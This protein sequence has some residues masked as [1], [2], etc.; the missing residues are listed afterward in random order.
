MD[1]TS[2][3]LRAGAQV[4][5]GSA[6]VNHSHASQPPPVSRA[7]SAFVQHAN[8]VQRRLG[9]IEGFVVKVKLYEIIEEAVPF[10]GGQS[11]LRVH[12]I[13]YA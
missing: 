3:F 12:S 5:A 7:G 10:K 2:L 9:A 8:E 11:M 6:G 1:L 4:K 13:F